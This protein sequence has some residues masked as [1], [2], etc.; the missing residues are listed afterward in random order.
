MTTSTENSRIRNIQQLL[1]YTFVV[2]PVVAGLDK[3]FGLLVNWEIYF[4]PFLIEIFP[5]GL[6]TT[7]IIVGIIEI[8]AGLIVLFKTE[9]GAYIVCI[10]LSLIALTLIIGGEYLDIA[11]RDIVMAISAY[12]LARLTAIRNTERV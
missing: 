4:P 10:W 5:W 3:F 2:L 9:A 6:E 8:I 7:V 11:V 12:A 1:K